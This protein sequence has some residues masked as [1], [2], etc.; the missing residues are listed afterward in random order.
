MGGRIKTVG[1]AEP[2]LARSDSNQKTAI[3]G[4]RCGE[5]KSRKY[6]IAIQANMPNS[7]SVIEM[8]SARTAAAMP[9]PNERPRIGTMVKY[10][11]IANAA[12]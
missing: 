8:V 7:K 6:V 4:S 12:S 11:K 1:L 10:W 3:P 2:G 5:G 9:L